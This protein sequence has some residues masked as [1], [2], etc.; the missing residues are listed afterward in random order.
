MEYSVKSYKDLSIVISHF[1][2][3]PLITQKW[4]DFELFNKA[5]NLLKNKEHLTPE[6][7][8]LKKYLARPLKAFMNKGLSE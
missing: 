6:R 8:D 4:A 3:Y 7:M 1:K 2:K 5:F